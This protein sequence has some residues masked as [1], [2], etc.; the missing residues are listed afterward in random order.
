MATTACLDDVKNKIPDITDLVKQTDYDAKIK[1]IEDKYLTTSDYNK[2][3]NEILDAK[4]KNKK[5]VNKSDISGFMNNS[6]LNKRIGTLATKAELKV[7]QVNIKKLQLFDSFY[8]H[9]KS[10]FE[11]DGTQSY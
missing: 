7:K 4:I 2:F 11:D 10:H 1:D 6:D 8:F 9:V 3:T 5:L